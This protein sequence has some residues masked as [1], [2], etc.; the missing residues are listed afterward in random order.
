MIL[1]DVKWC[2]LLPITTLE[3]HRYHTEFRREQSSEDSAH[4]VYFLLMTDVLR[5]ITKDKK[6]HQQPILLVQQM[7]AYCITNFYYSTSVQE[8]FAYLIEQAAYFSS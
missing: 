8:M 7:F 6:P 3:N 5:N 2:E 1:R 4:L